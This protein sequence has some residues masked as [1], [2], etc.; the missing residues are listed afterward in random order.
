MSIPFFRASLGFVSVLIDLYVFIFRNK[1][2]W[3]LSALRKWAIK[4]DFIRELW[5]FG[6]RARGAS[7]PDSDIDIALALMPPSGKHNWALAAYVESFDEWKSEL[8]QIVEWD[9]SLVA[10]GPD[11]EMDTIVR[12]T[13][14]LLWRRD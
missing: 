14:I 6:S 4:N 2:W 8:R 9:I 11:F 7:R 10:I 1:H 3:V 12:T 13:G 5:L